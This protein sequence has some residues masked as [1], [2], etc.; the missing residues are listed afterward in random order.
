VDDNLKMYLLKV[1]Y[2]DGGRGVEETGSV[3]YLAVLLVLN[4]WML[5]PAG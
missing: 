1:G 2:K 5:V 3:S 4:I